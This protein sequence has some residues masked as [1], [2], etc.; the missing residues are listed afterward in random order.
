MKI[1]RLAVLVGIIIIGMVTIL[2]T[3]NG[4]SDSDEEKIANNLELEVE[5]IID[6]LKGDCLVAGMITWNPEK[7]RWVRRVN[8]YNN[9]RE[10]SPNHPA[11][12]YVKFLPAPDWEGYAW[13]T[14]EY[15]SFPC[16]INNLEPGFFANNLELEVENIIDPLKGDCLVAG[17]IT[18]NPEKGRWVRRVNYYNNTREPSPNHPAFDYVKFLPAPDWEG[19]AWETPEYESF[20]CD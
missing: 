2:G 1:M 18:W 19:Y 9:T 3:G 10:P 16:D 11:F 17:M 14:P 5:N 4:G 7:G 20:P 6:P 8:Y 13:E 15:E 12:D